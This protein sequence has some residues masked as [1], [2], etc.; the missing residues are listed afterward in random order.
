RRQAEDERVAPDARSAEGQEAIARPEAGQRAAD[1]RFSAAQ[2]SLAAARDAFIELDDKAGEARAAHAG[3]LERA[4]A[5]ASEVVRLRE[6][7]RE[8][9]ERITTR[10]DERAQMLARRE[11]LLQSVAG[12]ERTLDEAIRS[13]D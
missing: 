9:E 10:V 8:L 13:L 1:E 5:L 2:R 4:A 7:A 6:A 12:G 11:E 3:L